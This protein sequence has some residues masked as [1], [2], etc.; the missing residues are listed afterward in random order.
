LF[1]LCLNLVFEK[2]SF[3]SFFNDAYKT[4]HEIIIAIIK[5]VFVLN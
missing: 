1:S 5:Q 2:F 4:S 3:V